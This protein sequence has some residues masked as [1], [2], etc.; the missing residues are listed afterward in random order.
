M[1]RLSST[2]KNIRRTKDF[3]QIDF[4][5]LLDRQQQSKLGGSLRQIQDGV[6]YVCLRHSVHFDAE[7]KE[8]FEV[9]LR[10][11]NKKLFRTEYEDSVDSTR[12]QFVTTY[13]NALTE[14][15]ETNTRSNTGLK[16][17]LQITCQV[18][19]LICFSKPYS[20]PYGI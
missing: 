5:S 18:S 3:V 16:V 9:L 4:Q 20:K 7:L 17:W 11:S 14:L 19:F 2:E 12:L 8:D 15:T 1:N 6:G 10:K 13:G